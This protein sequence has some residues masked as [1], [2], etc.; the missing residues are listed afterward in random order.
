MP[1]FRGL[2]DTWREGKRGRTPFSVQQARSFVSKT[3]LL[4][5]RAFF[6]FEFARFLQVG[7]APEQ[8]VQ[9]LSESFTGTA[10]AANLLLN[11]LMLAGEL[12][13]VFAC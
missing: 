1:K 4:G 3:P 9:L 6:C 7:G 12:V 5:S 11:W 13:S 10:Q 8:V 2:H